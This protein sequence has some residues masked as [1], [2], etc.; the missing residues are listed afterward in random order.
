MKCERIK[1]TVKTADQVLMDLLTSI[2][3]C[4]THIL[5]CILF[6]F[7]TSISTIETK[8]LTEPP[9]IHNHPFVAIWS[10]PTSN[11]R[12]HEILLDL[13]AF[14]AVTMP[15]LVPNHFLITYYEPRLGLYPRIHS[16]TGM[17][18]EGGIPQN[19]S[20]EEHLKKIEESDSRNFDQIFFRTGCH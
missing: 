18:F 20:L 10:T 5:F 19:G 1:G 4:A 11:C 13:A 14:S 17:S 9:L 16:Q 8:P 6:P 15:A 3:V 2:I 7:I 12:K